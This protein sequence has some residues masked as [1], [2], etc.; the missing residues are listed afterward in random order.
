MSSFV[1]SS[2]LAVSPEAFWTDQSLATVNYELEP[3]IHMTAPKKW[4]AMRLELVS[5]ILKRIYTLV[6]RHRHRRL[7][8]RYGGP[9]A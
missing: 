6:F 9:G 2:K 7:K 5:P 8:A 3:W 1:L 4:R